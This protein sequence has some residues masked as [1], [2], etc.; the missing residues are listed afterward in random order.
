MNNNKI[1]LLCEGKN[2]EKLLNILLDEDALIIKRD[3]LIG[4]RPLPIPFNI[5]HQVRVTS[6][7]HNGEQIDI[8][9]VKDSQKDNISIPKEIKKYVSKDRVYDYCTKPEVEMLL[10]Y[11][12]NLIDEYQKVKS[13]VKPKVFAKRNIVYKGK[14]YDNS[15]EFYAMY[16]DGPENKGK[17][18][19][20]IKGYKK[21]QKNKKGE[22]SLA[23]LLK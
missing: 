3:D 7:L 4:L 8:I 13:R 16:Y 1:L 10:I 20:N 12:E 14:R 15:T 19:N 17:L 6:I 23:D 5:K 21:Y 22:K 11:N 2:E 9:R 18:V